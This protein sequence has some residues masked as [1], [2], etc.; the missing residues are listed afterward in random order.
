MKRKEKG[1]EKTYHTIEHT[2]HNI[3]T[4]KHTIEMILIGD[5]E[6]QIGCPVVINSTKSIN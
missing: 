4:I 1:F 5:K 6:Q 2:I 3:H